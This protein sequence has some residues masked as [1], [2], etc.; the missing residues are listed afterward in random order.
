MLTIWKL[1]ATVSSYSLGGR[2]ADGGI[3][4]RKVC[5]S[6]PDV[7]ETDDPVRLGFFRSAYAHTRDATRR[8]GRRRPRGSHE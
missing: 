7:R 6:L 3:E 1:I 4:S 2:L 5:L 8:L